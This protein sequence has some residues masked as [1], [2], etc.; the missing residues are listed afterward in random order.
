MVHMFVLSL[1][2]NL[3]LFKFD[4]VSLNIFFISFT[5][6]SGYIQIKLV[7]YIVQN[8]GAFTFQS[9]S[10]QIIPLRGLWCTLPALHSNLV[11]FKYEPNKDK[12]KCSVFTIPI[13]FYSNAYFG[14]SW[15]IPVALYIPIWFY[16]NANKMGTSMDSIQT[17][18]SNLVLFKFAVCLASP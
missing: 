9:G 4:F 8:K 3:V 13:W 6:Q 1:H 18:H 7:V 11:L 10:I 12:L 2:S 15:L 14:K 5:F 17:L 16:S